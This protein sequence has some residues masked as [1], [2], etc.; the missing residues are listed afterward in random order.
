MKKI[1]LNFKI[2][3][4]WGER[5]IICLIFKVF[6]K[7]GTFISDIMVHS[8][9]RKSARKQLIRSWPNRWRDKM[10]ESRKLAKVCEFLAGKSRDFG[11]NGSSI[12]K[13]ILISE[14][15]RK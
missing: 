1:F 7:I 13:V 11:D 4:N 15:L 2:R 10:G 3:G 5:Q 14:H 6:P 12:G 9:R 8:V